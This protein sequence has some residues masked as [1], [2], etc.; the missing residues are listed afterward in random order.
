M[1]TADQVVQAL[2][3][4]QTKLVLAESC[5]GGL[6]AARLA[7]V[8]SVSN[9]LCGSAVTYRSET[10]TAWL[11]VDQ[12]TIQHCTA[13]SEEVAQQMVAGVLHLTPEADLAAAITGHLGPAAPPGFDGVVFV[14]TRWRSQP[15][16]HICRGQLT[17]ITRVDRQHEAADLV[18]R[19]LLIRLADPVH[20]STSAE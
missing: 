7:Q 11:S 6:V 14:A 5:T 20:E 2:A 9:W 17:A 15:T 18:L 19:Q 1:N 13:V 3:Q 10:K 12:A 4:R 16:A 8:P